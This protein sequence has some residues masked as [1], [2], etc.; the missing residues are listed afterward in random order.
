MTPANPSK[1]TDL[2]N[3]SRGEAAD[4]VTTQRVALVGHCGFDSVGLK[5]AVL[6]AA[7]E[8]Q[9]VHARD[10]AELERL[11]AEG[12]ALVLFNRQLDYG[13]AGG[14]GVATIERLR[15]RFPSLKMMLVSNYEDAQDAAE[16]AGALPGFGK[17]ELGNRRVT[18]L[19][20]SAIG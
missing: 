17:N 2:L 18:E 10:D 14:T 3:A 20:K 11:A 4:R 7:P 6:K 15:K 19:L 16:K 8:A 1:S 13:F 12:V 5:N 9:I